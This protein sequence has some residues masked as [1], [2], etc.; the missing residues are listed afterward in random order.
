MKPEDLH[1]DHPADLVAVSARV[2]PAFPWP[3]SILVHVPGI[4][5]FCHS[6]PL[7]WDSMKSSSGPRGTMPVGLMKG[8]LR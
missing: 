8:W 4:R 7:P 1:P 3:T 6:Q 5:G 2:R